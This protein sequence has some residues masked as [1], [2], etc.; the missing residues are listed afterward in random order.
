M[1]G[2]S[3][4]TSSTV[5]LR[6]AA[7]RTGPGGR[8]GSRWRTPPAARTA[9]R[10]A[11]REWLLALASLSTVF[12][13]VIATIS[14]QPAERAWGLFATA[15]Y[16]AA[17][18]ILLV[19]RR[20][21]AG[22]AARW[23]A[24]GLAVLAGLAGAVLAPLG[25]L[26]VAGE[27]QPEVGVTVR[28]AALLLHRGTPY[29][30]AAALAAAHSPYAYNPY[31]PALIVF[32]LPRAVL[33]GGPLTDPRLWFGLVF[34]I[35]FGAALALL[36][37]PHPGWWTAVVT[38]SPVV[39]FPLSV[40]GDDLPVLGLICLGF[41][42]LA[43]PRGRDWS[44]LAAAGVVFGL[45]ASMKATA[46]PA[47]VIVLVLVAVRQGKRAA[48]LVALAALVVAGLADGPV[49]A[50][51]P[52]AMVL[53]TIT[54]PLGLAKVASPAASVLPGHLIA[55]ACE[56]RPL[57]GHR[58]GRAGGPGGR[59]LAGGPPTG[60]RAGGGV[61]AGG[62]PDRAVPARTGHPGRV[63]HVPA[64]PGRL[65]AADRTRPAEPGR[66]GGRSRIWFGGLRGR[67][68]RLGQP[69]SG[70]LSISAVSPASSSRSSGRR[71]RSCRT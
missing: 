70:M 20:W 50:M 62:R 47:L 40:G 38:A 7:D 42:L 63:L 57:G 65:A 1:T 56:R 46:W 35:T 26:A 8:Q 13:A 53:N 52:A 44:R 9:A 71:V 15:G 14:S 48:A 12:A 64:G 61:A 37:T 27:A 31:L 21:P 11:R 32:G 22:T 58:P 45:A 30:G 6:L 59:G 51:D 3:G 10:L 68:R 34:A 39:A 33:G 25:W 17:S 69:R 2:P 24:T 23:R 67:S 54:F 60:H 4:I 29:Q 41:A 66:A 16:A 36:G 5:T 28:S 49:A 19:A 18:L 55:S 43:E